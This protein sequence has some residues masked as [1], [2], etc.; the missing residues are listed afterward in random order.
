M[1][2]GPEIF[3]LHMTDPRPGVWTVDYNCSWNGKFGNVD[4]TCII[5]NKGSLARDQDLPATLS[6]VFKPEDYT[7][8]F[9]SATVAVVTD[10]G[11]AGTDSARPT[12]ST[13]STTHTTPATPTAASSSSDVPSSS[14]FVAVG[15][16]PT[17]AAVLVGAAA[18][19]LAA[20]LAL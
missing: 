10:T 4:V 7:D 1:T 14:N 9:T 13:T 5:N 16:L 20:A 12:T 18:G 17:G 8:Y 19:I 3:E 15:P 11:S 6:S 2:Q